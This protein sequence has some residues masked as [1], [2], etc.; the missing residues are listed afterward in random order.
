MNTIY[1]TARNKKVLFLKTNSGSLNREIRY[2]F[3]IISTQ[4]RSTLFALFT[5]P[6]F[7]E[8]IKSGQRQRRSK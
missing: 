3:E 1:S 8:Y 6:S 5:N 7:K 4:L 2:I